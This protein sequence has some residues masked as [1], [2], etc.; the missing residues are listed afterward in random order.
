ALWGPASSASSS[1]NR[2]RPRGFPALLESREERRLRGVSAW[3]CRAARPRGLLRSLGRWTGSAR[4][5]PRLGPALLPRDLVALLED[6]QV[7]DAG[8]RVADQREV[9]GRV[10]RR[11]RECPHLVERQRERRPVP[12]ARGRA[13]VVEVPGLACRAART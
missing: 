5:P 4:L 7:H 10:A 13:E 1:S 8:Q 3:L 11:E 12:P 6:K 2:R 9:T